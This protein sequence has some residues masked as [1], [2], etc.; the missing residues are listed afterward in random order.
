MIRH[1][2]S[3]LHSDAAE[4]ATGMCRSRAIPVWDLGRRTHARRVI[5]I[6]GQLQSASI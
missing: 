5:V 6:Q 3:E 1:W 2:D 4:S